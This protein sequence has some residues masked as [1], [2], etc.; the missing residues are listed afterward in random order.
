MTDKTLATEDSETS[1]KEVQANKV[2]TQDEVNDMMARLKG[3]LTKKL[4]KQWED[5]GDPDELRQI[6]SDYENK[7]LEEQKRRG[8][9]DRILQE[10]AEK[11][12]AVIKSKDEIIK[13]YTIDTPLLNAAAQYKAVNAEQVKQLLKSKVRLAET[14]DVEVLDEKGAVKYNDSGKPYQV[15]DLVKDFLT[16]NPHFVSATPSTTNSRNNINSGPQKI[17]V[18]KLDF[19]NPEHRKMYK[20]SRMVKK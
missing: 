2:Y 10:L 11:K 13:N 8:D 5:L 15:E 16:H 1:N 6:K 14:G 7:K 4:T 9:F 18:T 12:D 3:S 17:D 19:R 20:E